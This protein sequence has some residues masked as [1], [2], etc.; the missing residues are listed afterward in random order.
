[1]SSRNR[2]L[3]AEELERAPS[4]YRELSSGKPIA[5][6]RSALE[7]QGFAVDYVEEKDGRIFAAV[8]LGAVRLIDNVA[9]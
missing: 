5:E 1:M 8:F 9:R 3:S 6:I 7:A 2:R 4:L